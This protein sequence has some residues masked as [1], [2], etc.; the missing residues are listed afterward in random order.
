MD[1]AVSGTPRAILRLE[2][3]AVLLFSVAAY[4]AT[5]GSWWMF[6]LLLLVP[7]VSLAGYAAN[8]RLGALTYNL[9]HTYLAPASLAA[10]GALGLPHAMPIAIIWVAH[11]AMDRALGLGLKFPTAF[12]STHL[13]TVGRKPESAPAT[14]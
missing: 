7:D 3:L 5:E 1:T 2:G 12:E 6:A 8:P 4:Q 10:L 14:A 13:G 11:I 9:F